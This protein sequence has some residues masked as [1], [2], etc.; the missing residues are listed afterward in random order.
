[1]NAPDR[2][3]GFLVLDRAFPRAIMHCI[4][5]A[6]ESL[7]AI[8]GSPPDTFWNL[9]EKQLG[10]LRGELAYLHVHESMQFGLHE[11]LDARQQ[12]TN[13]VGEAIYE[14]F[15]SSSPL[16]ARRCGFTPWSRPVTEAAQ[17]RAR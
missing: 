11:F 4:D 1:M 16:G 6:N 14:T 17:M 2:I 10:Q 9:A 8:S 15:C 5:S 12:K 3:V 7:H 13:R